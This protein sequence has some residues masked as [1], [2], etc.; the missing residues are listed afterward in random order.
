M[1]QL[2]RNVKIITSF[3]HISKMITAKGLKG[4]VFL[5]D[6]AQIRITY[7]FIVD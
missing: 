4:N 5:K 1:N 3:L 7:M 6:C 2:V